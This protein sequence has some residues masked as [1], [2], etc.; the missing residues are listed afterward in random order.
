MEALSTQF[1]EAALRRFLWLML[2]IFFWMSASTDA[3]KA[4]KEL[5]RRRS[6]QQEAARLKPVKRPV[7][8]AFAG[9]GL[10]RFG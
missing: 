1:N 4:E 2:V 6:E 8:P 7:P 9:A 3:K 10:P 5:K